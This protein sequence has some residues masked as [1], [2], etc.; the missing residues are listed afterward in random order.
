M[1][2][3]CRRRGV[4]QHKN[5]EVERKLEEWRKA[6][7]ERGLKIRILELLRSSRPQDS[8][9]G[10]GS[11]ESENI[12]IA[13]IDVKVWGRRNANMLRL[14]WGEAR[15]QNKK[16]TNQMKRESGGNLK[17]SSTKEVEMVRDVVRRDGE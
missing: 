14:T 1:C 3:V 11:G 15:G 8:V 2:V 16:P 4:V 12:G 17:E 13:G 6:M 10:Q 5:E 7:Q 9:T